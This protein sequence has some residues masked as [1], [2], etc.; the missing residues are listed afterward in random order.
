MT[1]LTRI[2][3]AALATS[4][5]GATVAPGQ[6]PVRLRNVSYDP[7]REWWRDINDNFIRLYGKE[8]DDAAT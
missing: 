3:T 7:T 4:L 1:I 5:A 6:K 2:G 8:L